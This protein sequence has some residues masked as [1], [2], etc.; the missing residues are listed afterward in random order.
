MWLTATNGFAGNAVN[1]M[2]PAKRPALLDLACVA[3]RVG[4]IGR[5]TLV[6]SMAVLLELA[7]AAE[8]YAENRPSAVRQAA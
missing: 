5:H 4:R 7:R 1:A 8:T 6:P 2:P 3:E